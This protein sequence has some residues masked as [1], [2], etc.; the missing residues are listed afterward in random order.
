MCKLNLPEPKTQEYVDRENGKFLSLASKAE[1]T[2]YIQKT[3]CKG[4][5]SLRRLKN[6]DCYNNTPVDPMHT[7]KNISKR[8]IKLISGV[9]DT[10]K[11]RAEEENRSHFMHP[12]MSSVVESSCCQVGTQSKNIANKRAL[13]ICTP[14]GFDWSSKEIFKHGV[15]LKSVKWMHAISA[16]ILKYCVRDCLG[17]FQRKTVFELCDVIALLVAE[18]VDMSQLDNLEYRVHRVLSLLERDFPV[19]I[20]V[21]M[22]YLLHHIP[23]FIKRFGPVH[24]F[25]TFRELSFV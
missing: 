8:L 4:P 6:H 18:N 14:H 19:T 17:T 23:M 13:S 24:N 1:Q 21:I 15:H 10:R 16:G 7:T 9:T 11:V 2:Q 5:C 3:G 20:H 25:W 22:F 12:S